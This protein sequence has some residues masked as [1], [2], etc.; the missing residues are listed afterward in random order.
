MSASRSG[1]AAVSRRR[2]LIAA[3]EGSV[4]PKPRRDDTLI[5]ALVRVHR[6]R[7]RIDRWRRGIESGE[8]QSITDLAEE[9][10]VTDAY[11][12]RLLQARTLR[13][14]IDRIDVAPDGISVTLHAAGIRSLSMRCASRLRARKAP[15]QPP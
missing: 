3:P 11:V 7:R 14:L 4:L 8:A 10:G 6:W 13:L 12:C 15:A 1:A 5:K 2:K 9:E